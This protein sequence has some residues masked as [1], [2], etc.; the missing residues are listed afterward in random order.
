MRIG[1]S[2]AH[3]AGKTTLV[4]AL[5]A[6]MADCTAVDEPYY[7]LEEEGYEFEERAVVCGVQGACRA[8]R[9]DARSTAGRVQVAGQRTYR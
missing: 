3:G 6:H 1:I 2:G 8:V 4:E 9:G 7:L 5:C